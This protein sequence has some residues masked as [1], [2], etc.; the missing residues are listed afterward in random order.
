MFFITARCNMN[1]NMCFYYKEIDSANKD[2]ELR[3]SEIEKIAGSMMP[4]YQ[5]NIGGGEPFLRQDLPEICNA[6]IKYAKVC[7]IV[8]PTNGWYTERIVESVHRVLARYPKVSFILVLSI[9]GIKDQHD[10]IRGLQGSFARVM[11][12][13]RKLLPFR[14]KHKKLAI[15]TNTTMTHGNEDRVLELLRYLDVNYDFNDHILTLARFKTR[16]E[17]MLDVNL[18]K[19]KEGINFLLE[20]KLRRSEYPGLPSW[21][22]RVLLI[23]DIV[24][25]R[26]ILDLVEKKK[27]T[28]PCVAGKL[29][30]C[31]NEEGYLTECEILQ[32]RVGNL[33][34]VGFDFNKLYYS[35]KRKEIAQRQMKNKCACTYECYIP[36]NVLFNPISL[37]KIIRACVMTFVSKDPIKFGIDQ[38]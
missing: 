22:N 8:I 35:N 3:L 32:S 23:K 5:L 7:Q 21:L 11:C 9:D 19:Y 38:I 16:D 30:M 26:V 10:K 20:R 2:R 34:D 31:M 15:L 18:R 27:F 4:F 6:F 33:R 36:F 25:Y 28:A 12:T 24:R 29:A 17:G 1:C 13:Y 37:P 14:E